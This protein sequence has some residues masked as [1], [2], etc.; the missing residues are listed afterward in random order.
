MSDYSVPTNTFSFRPEVDSITIP[1][2]IAGDD[3]VETTESFLI[4]MTQAS[5]VSFFT[6]PSVISI[7]IVDD[8]GGM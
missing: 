8:D 1:I 6:T 3:Q 7:F 5:L 2:T 4:Q